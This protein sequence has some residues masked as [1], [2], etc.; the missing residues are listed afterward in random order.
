VVDLLLAA[1]AVSAEV[2]VDPE[3]LRPVELLRLVGDASRF[4]D[5]AGWRPTIA[6]EDTL[7]D[8]FA[9]WRD[10]LRS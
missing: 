3:R 9:Y 2:V 6:F 7:R 8:T 1:A 5:A 10:A 4:R